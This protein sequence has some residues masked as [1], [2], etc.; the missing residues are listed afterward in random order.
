MPWSKR[1]GN[2]IATW[3]TR[4]LAGFPLRDGQSG[5]RALNREASL[6]MALSGRYTYVQ[7]TLMQAVYKGLAIEQVPVE[8]RERKGES[9]LISSLPRY[10]YR[11]GHTIFV[12]F[13]DYRPLHLFLPLGGLI[14]LAGFGISMRVLVHFA[15]TGGVRPHLPSAIA[16]TL[17]IVVGLGTVFFGFVADMFRRNRNLVEEVLYRLKRADSAGQWRTP[18][19][20]SDSGSLE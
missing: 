19:S 16:A 4:I 13:R 7:E 5:F 6:K 15:E 10:A 9:R 2:R 11:A 17:L 1:V 12:T 14:F 8:F 18:E 3:V 20:K